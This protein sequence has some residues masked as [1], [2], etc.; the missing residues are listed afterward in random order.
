MQPIRFTTLFFV[1]LLLTISAC[2]PRPDTVPVTAPI[3]TPAPAPTPTLPPVPSA[4]STPATGTCLV[5]DW[6][7]SPQTVQNLL[8]NL[9]SVPSLQVMEGSLYL[10]FDGTNFAYHANGLALRSAFMDSFLDAKADILIDGTYQVEDDSL[11]FTQLNAANQLYEWVVVKGD[12]IRPF[13]GTSPVVPF[14]I[15][16]EGSYSCDEN[17]LQL[18]LK[19]QGE[20]IVIHLVRVD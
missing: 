8:L 12:Y 7:I 19:D 16:D 18:T 15:A 5:G 17:S 2:S 9:T 6:Q 10:K 1:C 3:D 4:T 11:R 14:E 20:Q 13:T